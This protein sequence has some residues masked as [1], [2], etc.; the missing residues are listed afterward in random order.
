MLSRWSWSRSV[1][2]RGVAARRR[3]L[4]PLLRSLLGFRAGLRPSTFG[5]DPKLG[6]VE[7]RRSAAAKLGPGARRASFPGGGPSAADRLGRA[8][9]AALGGA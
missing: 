5:S 1:A 8:R 3:V 4:S 6:F 2:A 9:L 7:P